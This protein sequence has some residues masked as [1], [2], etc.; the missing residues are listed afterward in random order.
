MRHYREQ[1]EQRILPTHPAGLLG[2]H[3]LN[4]A[5]ELHVIDAFLR[6]RRMGGSGLNAVEPALPAAHTT[7]QALERS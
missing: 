1:E 6:R 4:S 5:R 7:E 3:T 2:L